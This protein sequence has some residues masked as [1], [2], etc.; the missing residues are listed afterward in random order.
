MAPD[1]KQLL[2]GSLQNFVNGRLEVLTPRLQ[3]H[4]SLLVR[5]EKTGNQTERDQLPFDKPIG[6]RNVAGVVHGRKWTHIEQLYA[7]KKNW[8]VF[9]SRK[10]KF[11][12]G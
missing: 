6:T 4:L 2:E 1:I 9:G 10:K 8:M 3:N 11:K 5:W 7:F 12:N